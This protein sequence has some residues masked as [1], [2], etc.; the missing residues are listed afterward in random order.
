ML[1]WATFFLLFSVAS[2]WTTAQSVTKNSTSSLKQC[3]VAKE[4]KLGDRNLVLD[5][6]GRVLL[7]LFV[8][9][10]KCDENCKNELARYVND[11]LFGNQLQFKK[12]DTK[13]FVKG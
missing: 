4:W 8:S 3:S 6:R 5:Y 9:L 12:I 1:Y 10:E 11:A 2:S 13:G 7:L